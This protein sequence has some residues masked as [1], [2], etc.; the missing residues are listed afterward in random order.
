MK[1]FHQ[2]AA[3]FGRLAGQMA[4]RMS[5]DR[6][7]SL[8]ISQIASQKLRDPRTDKTIKSLAASTLSQRA[9]SSHV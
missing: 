5:H 1:N 9:G 6:K 8:R 4:L 7:T 3:E 2:R